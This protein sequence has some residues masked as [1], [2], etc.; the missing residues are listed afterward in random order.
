ML[1]VASASVALEASLA[2]SQ[3]AEPPSVA[4]TVDPLLPAAA[5]IDAAPE[6]GFTVPLADA[7]AAGAAGT[8]AADRQVASTL[9]LANAAARNATAAVNKLA[10][11]QIPDAD[12]FNITALAVAHGTFTAGNAEALARR[13]ADV[14]GAVAARASAEGGAAAALAGSAALALAADGAAVAGQAAEDA[15]ASADA[16]RVELQRLVDGLSF[17]PSPVTG[18]AARL[19][20]DAQGAALAL[21]VGAAARACASPEALLAAPACAPGSIGQDASA[22]LARE[23]AF[24]GILGAETRAAVTV[25][26]RAGDAVEALTVGLAGAGLDGAGTIVGG[27]EDDE[28]LFP[29]HAIED[30]SG[31]SAAAVVALAETTGVGGVAAIRGADPAVARA[32]SAILAAGNASAAAARAANQT[33]LAAVALAG[34]A[35][36]DPT[37]G[38]PS[39]CRDGSFVRDAETLLQAAEDVGA[40]SIGRARSRATGVADAQAAAALVVANAAGRA[41]T[42][43][44]TRMR[45]EAARNTIVLPV[46]EAHTV[47][48]VAVA[49]VGA[50]EGRAA[51]LPPAVASDLSVERGAATDAALALGAHAVAA[52]A[53]AL[54]VPVAGAAAVAEAALR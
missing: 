31:A 37:Q 44:A 27:L 54:G 2:P 1:C 8:A 5:S 38:L 19:A 49:Y 42:D 12:L 33:A 11:R 47:G 45:T 3:A 4:A 10:R 23:A 30:A 14:A 26:G 52:G 39:A 6:G 16:T 7:S 21:G 43:A 25:A 18:P 53:T 48:A 36:A 46:A 29:F 32:A 17:D 51:A 24:Q 22:T 35:C 28:V 50:T 9:P 34:E 13:E 20:A 41:A 15:P 40:A